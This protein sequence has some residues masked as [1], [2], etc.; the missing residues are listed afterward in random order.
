M[1]NQVLGYKSPLYGRRSCQFK[2]EPF[3]YYECAK[4]LPGFNQTEKITLYGICGGIPEYI[5]RI[6]N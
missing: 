2:I 4:M 3:K 1:E 5:T 6:D